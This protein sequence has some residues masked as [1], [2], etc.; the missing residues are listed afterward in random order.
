[1]IRSLYAFEIGEE[2]SRM[3]SVPVAMGSGN[4][5]A[6]LCIHSRHRNIDPRS[7]AFTY[8]RNTLR[9]SLFSMSGELLWHLDRDWAVVPG[10]W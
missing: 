3:R 10:I 9:M 7:E 6:V 1:M 8:A 4:E 2:F 5:D